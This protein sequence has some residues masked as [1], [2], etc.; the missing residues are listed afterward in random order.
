MTDL[1]AELREARARI[2]RLEAELARRSG[3]SGGSGALITVVLCLG[4]G[5][6]LAS[7]AAGVLLWMRRVPA[8]PPVVS[9]SPPPT[10][11]SVALSYGMTWYPQSG[12]GPSFVDVDGDGTKEIV[13]LAWQ[14]GNDASPL[15]VVA[16]ARSATYA[17]VWR[18]RAYPSQWQ[19]ELTHLAVAGDRIVVT[20]SRSDV[21]LIDARDGNELMQ[22]HAPLPPRYVCASPDEPATGVLLADLSFNAKTVWLD[23]TTGAFTPASK[24]STCGLVEARDHRCR[25]GSTEACEEPSNSDCHG[26]NRIRKSAYGRSEAAAV[27]AAAPAGAGE[28]IGTGFEAPRQPVAAAMMMSVRNGLDENIPTPF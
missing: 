12:I 3:G 16:L 26:P 27:G 11:A 17:P 7:G 1:E 18:S 21:H 4:V 5:V 9:V 22:V 6:V 25:A 10:P 2:A 28:V 13:G 20:D 8:R 19:S 23:A 24:G 15:H 14:S